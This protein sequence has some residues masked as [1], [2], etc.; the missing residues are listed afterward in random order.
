MIDI[1]KVANIILYLIHKQTT[2]LNDRKLEL[3]LFFMEYNHLQFCGKKIVNEEFIKTKREPKALFLNEIFEL[4]KAEEIL[5]EDD[6]RVFFIQEIMDFVDIDI[7]EKDGF[8]ELKFKKHLEEFEESLFTKDELYS[9]QKVVNLY[10]D[11]SSRSLAN[12]CFKLDIVREKS[13]DEIII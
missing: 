10:K 1:T 7:V 2:A 5:E 11:T 12:E 6:E 4:I 9:M 13:L 8:K 3:M